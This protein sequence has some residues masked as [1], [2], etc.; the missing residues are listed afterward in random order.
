MKFNKDIQLD[1]SFHKMTKK[2]RTLSALYFKE[3]GYIVHGLIKTFQKYRNKSYKYR[4]NKY[5]NRLSKE[6]ADINTDK[7]ILAL[8]LKQS[9][10]DY[11]NYTVLPKKRNEI[12]QA[13]DKICKHEFSLLGGKTV[14]PKEINWHIDFKSGFEWP[15]G[16]FYLEY[17]QVDLTNDADVKL[18]RELSRFHHLLILGQ[19]YL[20]SKNEKYAF[21]FVLQIKHWIK[22]NPLMFS[23][24]WGCAMDVSIRSANWI[25]ALNMF[26]DSDAIEESFLE[27]ILSSLYQHGWYIET[28]LEKGFKYRANHYDGD[29]G[30]LLLLGFVFPQTA[31]GNHWRNFSKHALFGEIRSQILPSGMQWEKTTFYH[32]LVLEIFAYSLFVIKRNNI[33]IPS[34]VEFRIWKMFSFIDEITMSDGHLPI[35]GD[36]DNARFLPFDKI[37]RN[38]IDFLRDLAHVYYQDES[39]ASVDRQQ[40]SS[41]VF[42]FLNSGKELRNNSM[43]KRQLGRD[44]ISWA[45]QDVGIYKLASEHTQVFINNSSPGKF[46]DDIFAVGSH[47]HA[48]LLS[49]I[50]SY[51]GKQVLVDPGSYIYTSDYKKRNLFRSTSMHNTISIDQK[52]QF[53]IQTR[54]LFLFGTHASVE[55]ILYDNISE[56]QKY[57]GSHNAYSY[58]DSGLI[59]TREV[60]LN[61]HKDLVIVCDKVIGND[62]HEIVLNYHFHPQ[63]KLESGEGQIKLFQKENLIGTMTF[64]GDKKFDVA[65]YDSEYSSSYGTVQNSQM[66]QLTIEDSKD[67]NLTTEIL[68]RSS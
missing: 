5:K 52:S 32:R 31:R 37:Y 12:V 60:K 26:I 44:Q 8:L 67:A 14:F 11:N 15:K 51:K 53:E 18:P 59:H 33:Q 68:F 29:L 56:V 48:D 6:L 23:I 34:D 16:T 63:I 45:K 41:E 7:P 64:K 65:I 42:F 54:D 43:T 40:I 22:E 25:Y 1:K 57:K 27:L 24:N 50:I 20:L 46:T 13:A 35:I 39:F 17:L 38:D 10:G 3:E 30:G 36:Q 28:N 58:L 21:E 61:K 47:A 66:I 9:F 19:A 4:I 2:E 49:L 62:Q 55:D